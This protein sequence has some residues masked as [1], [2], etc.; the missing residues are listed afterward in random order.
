MFSLNL[1]GGQGGKGGVQECFALNKVQVI[2]IEFA[3]FN[4]EHFM[5]LDTIFKMPFTAWKPARVVRTSRYYSSFC[6][7][8]V[9]TFMWLRYRSTESLAFLVP[10][11]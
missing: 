1:T 8:V 7:T 4:E 3:A 5:S 2:S 11:L 10:L 9:K 6:G